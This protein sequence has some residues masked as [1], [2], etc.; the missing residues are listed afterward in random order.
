[1]K[2]SKLLVLLAACATA[3]FTFTF[4]CYWYVGGHWRNRLPYAMF[5]CVAPAL[6]A[7]VLAK[8]TQAK[9]RGVTALYWLLFIFAMSL[10]AL[11][12]QL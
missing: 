5:V 11:L 7:F 10:Q 12:R 6:A 8:L 1:M 2:T 9:W 4:V 3:A